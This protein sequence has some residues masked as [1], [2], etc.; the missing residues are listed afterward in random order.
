MKRFAQILASFSFILLLFPACAQ[1][2]NDFEKSWKEIES[3]KIQGLPQSAIKMV[4]QIY[5]Q[6][7]V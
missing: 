2:H 5:D 4:D 1:Q 7:K 6:A 3:F